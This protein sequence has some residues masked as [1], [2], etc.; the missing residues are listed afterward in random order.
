MSYRRPNNVAPASPPDGS[1]ESTSAPTP[2]FEVEVLWAQKYANYCKFVQSIAEYLPEARQWSQGLQ[3]M[4]L[5]AFK[6]RIGGYFEEAVSHQR[7]NNIQ[8]R[9][10]A[11]AHVIRSNAKLHG[12][13]VSKVRPDD[14]IK[15]LRYGSLFCLLLAEEEK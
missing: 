9:D 12:F 2:T 15:L 14:Y 5:V 13:D 8:E 4:P 1:T 11:V 7:Q 3:Y 6:L 10:K